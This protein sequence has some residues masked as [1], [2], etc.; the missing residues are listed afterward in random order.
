MDHKVFL[1][2]GGNEDKRLS[3]GQGESIKWLVVPEQVEELALW[4]HKL[5]DKILILS[6]GKTVPGETFKDMAISEL[7]WRYRV[8]TELAFSETL[9]F[10]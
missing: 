5:K 4:K 1:G 3:D 8:S 7:E 2:E 6:E 10:S 9:V